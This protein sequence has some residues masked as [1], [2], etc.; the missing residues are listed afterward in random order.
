MDRKGRDRYRAKSG[1]GYGG[2]TSYWGGRNA[3]NCGVLID[4]EGV[5]RFNLPPRRDRAGS[6][7]EAGLIVDR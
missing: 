3:K 1:Q 6:Q 7:P 2:S 5:D 4:L